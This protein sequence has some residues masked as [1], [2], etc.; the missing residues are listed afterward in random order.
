MLPENLEKS[1]AIVPSQPLAEQVESGFSE[2][3]WMRL[4]LFCNKQGADCVGCRSGFSPTAAA[5]VGLKP[6]LRET[7]DMASI[8]AFF[9]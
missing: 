7:G 3:M 8:A 6:D 2:G 5:V 1:E 9:M 4:L